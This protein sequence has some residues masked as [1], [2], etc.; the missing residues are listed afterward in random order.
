M[1]RKKRPSKITGTPA[2]AKG[3]DKMAA[4]AAEFFSSE[5]DS[6]TA[7]QKPAQES[8]QAGDEIDSRPTSLA[9]SELSVAPL[10]SCSSLGYNPSSHIVL[11]S[12]IH[13]RGQHCRQHC[14][15]K[16]DN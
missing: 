1:P 10:S 16:S 15:S 3:E 9:L 6:E 13:G 7:R 5:A 4:A 8:N 2:A 12:K 11:S 14:F